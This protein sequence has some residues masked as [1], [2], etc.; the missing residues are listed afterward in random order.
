MAVF[1]RERRRKRPVTN[2]VT[3]KAKI[4]NF[5][6]Y[7]KTKYAEDQFVNIVKGRESNQP[8]M[9]SKIQMAAKVTEEL[10]YFSDHKMHRTIRRTMIFSFVILEKI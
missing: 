3:H 5:A 1:K 8:N 6:E 10:P 4:I 7:L 9:N 2:D